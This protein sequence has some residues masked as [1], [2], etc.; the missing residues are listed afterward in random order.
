M[1][2]IIKPKHIQSL[3]TS[4]ILI[5]AEIC[6]WSA[7]ETDKEVTDEVTHGKSASNSAGK[8]IKNLMAN[9]Q[10]HAD[11]GRDRAGWYNW[12][13]AQTFPWA[14]AW[15]YLPNARIASFMA[16]FNVRHIATMGLVDA[17]CNVYQHRI[18]NMAFTLG[19]MFKASDYPTVEQVRSK[20]R[21]TMHTANVPE[22]DFRN[23]VSQDLADDL[24]NHYCRQ[25]EE[26]KN[27]IV[28][29]QRGQ[30]I[31]VMQAITKSCDMHT[32]TD[33][34]GQV[35][36]RRGKIYDTTIARALEYCDTFSQFNLDDDPKLEEARRALQDTLRDVDVKKLKQ[37]DS[38]RV[39]VKENIDDILSKFGMSA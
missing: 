34:N 31:E 26:L 33:D 29:E 8:F 17:L 28:T 11:L 1:N 6:A 16:E 10:E 23:A 2:T 14:G 4:G 27:A 32:V 12:I 39:V 18:G 7:T 25:A 36:V 21:V 19:S 15:R 37:S 20:Y 30:F 38:M 35:K 9:V 13:K 3:A 22:G 5:H 24:H